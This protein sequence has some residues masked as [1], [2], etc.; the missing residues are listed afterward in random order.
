MAVLVSLPLKP[1]TLNDP[2][3]VAAEPFAKFPGINDAAAT[4]DG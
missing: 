4:G 1:N 2:S 3:L